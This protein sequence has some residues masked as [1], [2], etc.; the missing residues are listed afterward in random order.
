LEV[1][2]YTLVGAGLYLTSDWILDR[3]EVS[4]G[5]RFKNRSIVFFAIIMIL[6][7]IS[8]NFIKYL[9]ITSEVASK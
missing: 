2:L 7:F 1:I 8:F 9:L 5:G 4:R 6:A 3:L